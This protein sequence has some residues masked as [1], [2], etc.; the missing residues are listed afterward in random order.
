MDITEQ[1]HDCIIENMSAENGNKQEVKKQLE[2]ELK[3][4]EEVEN[5]SF[6]KRIISFVCLISS[7]SQ[8]I[9]INF[10]QF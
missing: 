5:D 1:F 9:S 2:Q 10:N 3:E 4:N 6:T 8:S 7:Q